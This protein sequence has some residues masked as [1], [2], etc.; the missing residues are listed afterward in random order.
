MNLAVSMQVSAQLSSSKASKAA[1]ASN[2][3]TCTENNGTDNDQG[4]LIA[5]EWA[6]SSGG[7][8][9]T[10]LDAVAVTRGALSWYQAH[11]SS[12]QIYSRE[13]I[14]SVATSDVCRKQRN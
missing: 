11:L 9:I 1:D 3:D 14:S 2:D 8:I 5:L 10:Y 12:T 4:P 7:S 13:V 6:E